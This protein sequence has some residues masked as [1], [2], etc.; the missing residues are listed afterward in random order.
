MARLLTET[1]MAGPTSLEQGQGFSGAF[2]RGARVNSIALDGTTV[3]ID[4]SPEMQNVGGSC[5]VQ[6]IRASL[7]A[8]LKQ[9]PNVDRVRI[10]AGGSE[11][12]ALQP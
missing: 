9:L 11:E 7:E 10:T 6:A 3:T 1:V 5:R 4:F 2:P 8:T 12:L